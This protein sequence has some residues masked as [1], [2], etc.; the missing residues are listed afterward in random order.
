[1]LAAVFRAMSV[2]SGFADEGPGAVLKVLVLEGVDGDLLEVNLLD[3]SQA[4][5]VGC[6]V[7]IIEK[8]VREGHGG[9][10]SFLPRDGWVGPEGLAGGQASSSSWVEMLVLY[11]INRLHMLV[12]ARFFTPT[13]WTVGA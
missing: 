2:L 4:V 6:L 3:V 9:V 11:A 7:F 1:M 8:C 5:V 13:I 12:S 10:N